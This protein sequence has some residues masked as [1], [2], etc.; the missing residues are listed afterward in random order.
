[1]ANIDA[2]VAVHGTVRSVSEASFGGN[3]SPRTVMGSH[4]EVLTEPNGG[5]LR[6]LLRKEQ[7]STAEAQQLVGERIHWQVTVSHWLARSGRSAGLNAEFVAEVAEPVS[8]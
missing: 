5:F 1:M 6:V 7:L 8:A 3:D 4:V 2:V